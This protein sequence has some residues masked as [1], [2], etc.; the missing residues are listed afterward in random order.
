MS[1]FW[2]LIFPICCYSCCKRV[3]IAHLCQFVMSTCWS[4][5]CISFYSTLKFVWCGVKNYLDVL[6]HINCPVRFV[7]RLLYDK[8]ISVSLFQLYDFGFRCCWMALCGNYICFM[9]FFGYLIYFL[10]SWWVC[11]WL[12][13]TLLYKGE[14]RHWDIDR[15]VQVSVILCIWR[16]FL[17]MFI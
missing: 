5:R 12:S 17:V 9:K 1:C 16:F 4:F 2:R 11:L 14:V 6:F 7:V 13:V 3:D 8:I 15:Y 10:F